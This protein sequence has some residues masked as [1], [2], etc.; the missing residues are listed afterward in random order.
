MFD[1]FFYAP[2][3][4]GFVCEVSTEIFV[5]Y[6]EITTSHAVEVSVLSKSIKWVVYEK[7]TGKIAG[8][9]DLVRPPSTQNLETSFLVNLSTLL[10]QR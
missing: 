2:A 9:F 5:N 6:L 7:N 8:L 4:H 3:R 10:I 1:D